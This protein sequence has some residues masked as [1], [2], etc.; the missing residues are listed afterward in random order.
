[1]NSAQ[2][3][4][5]PEYDEIMPEIDQLSLDAYHHVVFRHPMNFYRERAKMIGASNFDR[6]LDAGHGFGQWSVAMAETCGSVVGVDHSQNQCDIS[7]VLKRHYKVSNFSAHC[8]SVLEL[9]EM[10][11][12]ASFDLIFCWGVIMFVSREQAMT[13]FNRLLSDSGTL[14][15]GAV[16]TPE[17]WKYKHEKGKRDGITDENFYN[18]CKEGM[19]GLHK[20][21]GVNAFSLEAADEIAGRYGFS[22][23]RADFD[24]CIDF[25]GDQKL[26]FEPEVET[27]DQNIEIVMKKSKELAKGKSRS[28]FSS[29]FGR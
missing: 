7:N 22:V 9:D 29:I 27:Q 3:K 18:F 4:T 8:K 2:A 16:N 6:V 24:G 1:M 20:E 14:I 15:L 5:H 11:E 28:F 17:R 23:E 19:N 13:S 12:P 10:F 26:A 21:N 25:T